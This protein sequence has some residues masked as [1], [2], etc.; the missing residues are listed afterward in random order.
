METLTFLF[1]DI[2]GSTALLRR[3]GQDAY[4]QVLDDHHSFIRSALAVT[5]A[6]GT[7]RE[8]NGNKRQRRAAWLNIL[9]YMKGASH[10]SA[11]SSCRKC[12]R[13]YRWNY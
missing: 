6:G 9:F 13:D 1:T 10:A 2:E 12:R 11:I 3:I 4:A 8:L 5:I 7:I